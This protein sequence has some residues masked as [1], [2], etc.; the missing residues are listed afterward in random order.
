MSTWT[1]CKR[2]LLNHLR[3]GTSARVVLEGDSSKVEKRPALLVADT[4][5][6]DAEFAILGATHYAKAVYVKVLA[7][8]DAEREALMKQVR[9]CWDKDTTA[10]QTRMQALTVAGLF[11]IYPASSGELSLPM[12]DATAQVYEGLVTFTAHYRETA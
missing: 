9:R 3:T 11:N 4:D 7:T 6:G 1:E 5:G 2:L 8:T 10:G 12:A